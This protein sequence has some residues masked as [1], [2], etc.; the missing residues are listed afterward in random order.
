MA[1]EITINQLNPET[2]EYQTYSDKDTELIVQSQLDTVYNRDT[3]YIEY[4]AYDQNQNLIYPGSTIPLLDYDVRDGDVILNPE[5]D[6]INSGYDLGVYNILYN[7]YRKRLSSDISQKYFI[8]DISSDRTEIRLDSNIISNDLIISSSNSFIEYRETADYFVDFYLNFGLNQTVI[9]NNIQLETEDGI[10]PTLLIKLYEPLPSNFD[11]KDELWVVEELSLSQAYELNFPF[12]PTIEDDF[13]YISGPNYSLNITQQTSKGGDVYSF[14][15]LLQSNVTSSIN[16]IRSLLNE[17]EVNININ[18]EN[19]SNF[20]NFSSAQTRLE[21]F[22]YKAGLIESSSNQIQTF[23]SQ[24]TSNTINTQAYSSSKAVLTSQINSIIKNFDGYEYFLYFNSGS[25][26]SYPKQNDSPPYVLYSTSSAE[27]ETWL[28]NVNP[29]STNYGGQALSASNYD[30]NNRDWLYYAI[31]EYLRSD[32]AN[33]NYELFVDMVGQYYDNVWVYTKDISNK[34]DADNR[35]DY[36]ISKDLVADA[37]R[38]FAVKLYSNNFNTDDLFT[39]FLGLTP[40]GSAFPFPYMTGSVVDGSGDLAIPSGFE[41]VNTEISASNDIVPLT[42]VQKQVYKRI[43]HNIPHLLK[44]KG[45]IAGIRALITS[46]GIPDTI[47]RISEFG[48]KDRNES[49]DYDLKQ[50][51]FNYA[52]NTGIDANPK[53]TITSS[54]DPNSDFKPGGGAFSPN[55]VQFRFKPAPIPPAVDNLPS[56]KIRY[57]QSLWLSDTNNNSFNNLGAAVVLE[58][59][60]SGFR[61]GSYSGSIASPFDTWGT[62]KFYPNVGLNPTI[63]CSVAAP[64]F[65]GDWWSAQIT[66]TGSNATDATASLFSANEINGKIGFSGS[67]TK[68][69]LDDR[70]WTRSDFAALNMFADRTINSKVYEPFSGSFQEYRMFTPTISESKFLDYV[71]NPYSNEGNTLN[72]TP[73]EL[74]FRA[75]LG[76]QLNTGSTSQTTFTSIHPRI[77]GSAVQ[78]TQSFANDTSNYHMVNFSTGNRQWVVNREDIFQDQVPAGMKNRITNKIQT[79]NLILAE[80]PYGYQT[81]TSSQATI[82]STTSDVISP[83]ESI[84]QSSFI[85]QSYTPNVNYLEVAFSPSNQINDDIN[86]QLGYFNLGDYIGDPRQISSSS[87]T[88]PDLDVLRDAYFEKY[89][90]GYNIVDFVRLI[91]FFDNSLFK[92]IQDFTP[93][94]TSLASGVVI[95]QHLLERNRQRPAQV[96]SSLHQYSGSVKPFPKNYNTGSFDQPQYATSGSAIYKFTG[97][98]GGSFNRFNGLNSYFSGSNLADNPWFNNRFKLTQSW[99]ESFGNSV[100]NSLYFNQSSSQYISGSYLGPRF[101]IHNDQSEFY[102]GEFS[103]SGIV[104]TTQS[105]NP[106]CDPYLNI[107]STPILFKP[108]FF[109]DTVSNVISRG[110]FIDQNNYP[111]AG[112]AWVLSTLTNEGVTGIQQVI[113]IKLNKSDVND[114]EVLNYLDVENSIRFL[115]PGGSG[116]LP[117]G[118]EA[119]EYIITGRTIYADFV[120]LEISTSNLQGGNNY[121]QIVDGTEYFPITSSVNGGSANWSF[122]ASTSATQPS[123]NANGTINFASDT[124]SA[125]INQQNIFLNIGELTQEQNIYNWNGD[126]SDALGF[127]DAGG[128]FIT[129]PGTIPNSVLNTATPGRFTASS[130][131][132]D[133]TPNIPFSIT[134]SINFSSSYRPDAASNITSSGFLHNTSSYEGANLTPQG[135]TMAAGLT[136]FT[137]KIYLRTNSGAGY[138]SQA[139]AEAATTPT[140]GDNDQLAFGDPTDSSLI[141]GNTQALFSD[142]AATTV[143]DLPTT[144]AFSP[145]PEKYFKLA[146][147]AGNEAVFLLAQQVTGNKVIFNYVK[148]QI[149]KVVWVQT[150]NEATPN[151]FRPSTK[152]ISVT[153]PTIFRTSYNTQIPG[154]SGSD[155]GKDGGHPKVLTNGTASLNFSCSRLTFAGTPPSLLGSSGEFIDLTGSIPTLPNG[156]N[157]DDFTATFSNAIMFTFSASG[158]TNNGAIQANIEGI[159]TLA[160]AELSDSG[161]GNDYDY[162]IETVFAQPYYT[163][164]ATVGQNGVID[165]LSNF[166]ASIYYRASDGIGTPDETPTQLFSTGTEVKANLGIANLIASDDSGTVSF[167]PANTNTPVGFVSFLLRIESP[168]NLDYH[169]SNFGMDVLPKMSK[170]PTTPTSYPLVDFGFGT[171]YAQGAS[172][173]TQQ[174]TASIVPSGDRYNQAQVDVYLRVTGSKGGVDYDRVIT[175]SVFDDGTNFFPNSSGSTAQGFSG[176]IYPGVE[177]PFNFADLG[178][179]FEPDPSLPN[180]TVNNPSDMYYVEYSMSNWKAGVIQGE[181]QIQQEIDFLTDSDHSSIFVNYQTGLDGGSQ[182][183]VTGSFRLR[184]TNRFNPS[185]QQP[186]LTPSDGGDLILN[187]NFIAPVGSGIG[188]TGTVVVSGSYGGIFSAGDVFRFNMAASKG[189]AGSGLVITDITASINAGDSI[190]SPL[191]GNTGYDQFKA[192]VNTGVIISTYFGV[193]VLPFSLALDCQPLLNNY[194]AQRANSYLM[195]VDYDNASGPIVPVNFDQILAGTA[196]KASIPDS[197]YTQLQTINPRYD[198]AKT[199]SR[200]L[201]VW[202]IGDSNTFGKNPTIELRDAFF[203]Y[204]NDIDDPYPNINGITQVNLNYLIDEQGNALPPSLNRLSID[205]FNSVF[206]TTTNASLAVKVGSSKFKDLGSPA[207]IERLMQYM[208][209]IMYSQNSS[210]NYSPVIPLSGSGYISRYDNDDASDVVFASFTA[211]GEASIN[212][213]SP[214]QSVSYLLDPQ[215]YSGSLPSTRRNGSTTQ[216]LEG[217]IPYTGSTGKAFYGDSNFGVNDTNNIV[218]LETSVVT[219]YVSE[220]KRT[221]DELKMELHCYSGSTTFTGERTFNLESIDAKVYTETGKVYLI[222]DVDDYGWFTYEN[223]T[224]TVTKKRKRKRNWFLN[225]WKYSKVKVPTGGIVFFVDWEMYDTLWDRGIIRDKKPKRPGPITGIEWIFKANTGNLPIKKNDSIHWQIK[226]VF[227][228]TRGR[229]QQGVFFPDTYNGQFTPVKI[230]GQGAY[231]HLLTNDNRGNVPFWRITGSTGG[232]TTALDTSI[233]VMSSSNMNEAYG[234]GYFQGPMPYYPGPSPYFPGGVEP[235]GTDFDEIQYPLDIKEGDEIRFG[236]NEN[237][238]YRIEEVFAPQENIEYDQGSTQGKPRLKIRL[239]GNIGFSGSTSADG[240]LGN[241][242]NLDFFLI[243]RPISSPNILYLDQQFPYAAISSAS[244]S[245]VSRD[246]GTTLNNGNDIFGLIGSA[247]LPDADTK[248]YTASISTLA[249]ATTP[250]ILYPDYPTTYLIESASII[251]NDLISKGIIES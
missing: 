206:P 137:K 83:I 54:F 124:Q 97:G 42:D 174:Y 88:Y 94:R 77:T 104:V 53:N 152:E 204:F 134:A 231:D 199:T 178:N 1:Q 6:L 52:F 154:N 120:L 69:G 132:I 72:S 144:L 224:R 218:S 36:G 248:S 147:D 166:T 223:I 89:I 244:I 182:L 181:T 190:W 214:Q 49:Q 78:I 114:V 25:L 117:N 208:T 70:D 47:L 189:N 95:K 80:A 27:V 153:S 162:M 82:S 23:L 61:T 138:T 44:T 201:N 247:S 118:I 28:G 196:T 79:E 141:V 186:L 56:S 100:L 188:G 93:A 226:G 194:N 3:D 142:Q 227:K 159:N 202:T 210:N 59:T 161:Q 65:N 17:K 66:F 168:N 68:L 48:G 130:Y 71:V 19:Y 98:P 156:A 209:P 22:I 211:A 112:F 242:V 213:F 192:P 81:P 11:I 191:P 241:E 177:I 139:A 171:A 198:G 195:N 207:P 240:W 34:F 90:R 221:R 246:M 35:L 119:T 187:R 4:Y 33:R 85:S 145:L 215:E 251:V 39:A 50:D 31:P 84:Q 15:T 232:S 222:E 13:T 73:S 96:S 185:T 235:K 102:T 167:A 37:I 64:F 160:R 173:N 55:T 40:S 126:F 175:S 12:E 51:V 205:T 101:T 163:I 140:S 234:T 74:M 62:L 18:Y 243:R 45:T 38:D 239:D 249:T 157:N 172:N 8:T 115:F 7:F 63:T 57:S 46:Y 111:P 21:N 107:N 5:Q 41:Y 86:A 183:N 2:F 236:N 148:S 180:T 250:G 164:T 116:F 143:I 122:S 228:D 125:D 30:E 170:T 20:V 230:N 76:S 219:S 24:V 238:T 67:E 123:R 155:A 245:T 216:E 220:T 212:T 129:P 105:L 113:N 200:Y 184:K 91:K 109:S 176:S 128:Q 237:F 92:M 179:I 158:A 60:G 58:Y 146:D 233:L 99:S 229:S 10:D 103:G 43:Y 217:Y 16:Q 9:A 29:G 203:G 197:N 110:T 151:F 26:Y 121:Y 127:F 169:V 131:T 136:T 135:F 193:G 32:P 133:Y 225:R 149:P 108:I 150:T 87:Y 75:A 165:Q 106:G 14:D